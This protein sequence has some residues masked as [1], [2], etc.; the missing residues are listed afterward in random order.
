MFLKSSKIVISDTKIILNT[1]KMMVF[2]VSRAPM[3][4]KYIHMHTYV[5][6]DM[7]IYV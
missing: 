5:Y 4:H 1:N 2:L 7:Y 6:A 3:L